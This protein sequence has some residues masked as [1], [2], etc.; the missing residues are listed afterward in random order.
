MIPFPIE[1]RVIEVGKSYEAVGDTVSTFA[2][3]L[4][5]AIFIALLL[6]AG[7]AYRLARAA[8]SPVE[9]VVASERSIT[10]GDLS[11]RVPVQHPKDEVGRLAATM[12]DHLGRLEAA[13]ARRAEALAHQRRF[14]A[15][16][17]HQLRTP[18]TSIEGYARMLAEWGHDDPETAREGAATIHKLGLSMAPSQSRSEVGKGS[19][20]ALQLPKDRPTM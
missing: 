5:A 12:N 6:S 19:T 2:A 20:F 8:L 11:K 10:A 9:K 14:V 3:L 13:F 15:D 1:A 16:A 7:G 18:L 4:A 17:S